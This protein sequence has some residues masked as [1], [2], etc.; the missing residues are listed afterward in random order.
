M[1]KAK[2]NKVL[3]VARE[4]ALRSYQQA[5]L[6][7]MK[8]AETESGTLNELVICTGGGKTMVQSAFAQTQGGLFF[9]V[10]PNRHLVEQVYKSF[11]QS[12]WP[13]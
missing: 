13:N 2:R 3:P 6:E 9:V 4:I 7:E 12:P 11:M 8:T 1:Y 5:A 10:C